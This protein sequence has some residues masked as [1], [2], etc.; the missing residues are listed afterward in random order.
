MSMN[1]TKYEFKAEIKKLLDILSRSLYQHNE[2][3][4]RELISNSVDALK[5]IHF[6]SLT[7]KDIQDPDAPLKIEVVLNSIENKLIVKDTGVGMN[8]EELIENLGTIAGSGSQKFLEQLSQ[9]EG[10]EKGNVDLDIIGQFGVGFYSVFMVADKVQVVSKS[11][12]KGK[13]SY[14]WESKGTGDFTIEPVEKKDRGT[15]VILYL[16]EDEHDFLDEYRI[17]TII[18]KYSN[19][20]SFPI[21]VSEIK[22]K[23]DEKEKE[24]KDKTEKEEEK[25]EPEPVNDLE[26]VW[27]KNPN[28]ITKDEYKNFYHFISNR[29]DDYAH[30][31]H[32]NTDGAVQF[33]SIMFIPESETL[34]F[35]RPEDDYGLTLYS[36]NVMIMKHCKELFPKWL[37]FISGVLESED[38]P[39][40]ISRETIQVNRAMIKINKV[41]MKKIF[42]ELD[43]IIKEDPKKYKKIWKE[44][45]IYFKEG[46]AT[47]P[48]RSEKLLKYLRFK[49]TQTENDQF[50]SLEDYINDMKEDQMDIFYLVGENINSMKMSPHLGYYDKNNIEVILFDDPIDNFVM[51][52]VRD[53]KKTIGEGEDK[54]I[55]I[56]PF[57]PVDI[58][59]PTKEQEPS[60]EKEKKKDKKEEEQI[61]ENTRKF[62]DYVKSILEEK[63][64]DVKVS[65]RLYDNPCRLANPSGG[66]TSSMQRAMRYWSLRQSGEEFQIPKKIL[67]FN[68]EHSLIKGLIDIYNKDPKD[69]KIE[70]IVTQLFENCLLAEGDLPQPSLMVPRINQ[71]MEMLIDEVQN[72]DNSS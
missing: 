31:I 55:K 48:L 29:Y 21:Y 40:N 25:K 39:L 27:K 43:D 7:E 63:I 32:Y 3:F 22:P 42:I 65:D 35:L 11:Y 67:E 20:V 71:I 19:Y 45:G 28:D 26:P 33:R 6:I 70:P 14:R 54:E 16:K 34:G 72:K 36:K 58:T 1:E 60:D 5:K 15:E 18:K 23:E 2:I 9:K 57:T 12:K 30:V 59:E 52:N 49:S 51:M 4:L 37:R 41:L 38:I 44:F 62:L 17:N 47:D 68:Q 56:Y 10:Q 69:S 13:N 46:I 8:K 24:K 53:Y 61:P 50:R 64:I 66:M